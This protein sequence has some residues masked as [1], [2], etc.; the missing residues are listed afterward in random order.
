MFHEMLLVVVVTPN[1]ALGT[2]EVQV[3][4]RVLQMYVSTT[5][6]TDTTESWPLEDAP[7]G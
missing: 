7:V 1:G 5:G 2:I 6:D 3:T 4:L